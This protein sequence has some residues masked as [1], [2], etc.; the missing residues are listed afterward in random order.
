[1][2]TDSWDSKI[3]GTTHNA[4]RDSV[5]STEVM[6]FRV[7]LKCLLDMYCYMSMYYFTITKLYSLYEIIYDKIIVI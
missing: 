6:G 2:T 7:Q 3:R 4:Q 5:G 1:M